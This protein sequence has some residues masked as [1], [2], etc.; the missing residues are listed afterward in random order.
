M[1]TIFI[2]L[3]LAFQIQGILVASNLVSTSER[4]SFTGI[5]GDHYETFKR[6]I[7]IFKE[8]I[9]TINNINNDN[10]VGYSETQQIGNYTTTTVS[11][12]YPAIVNSLNNQPQDFIAE[13]KAINAGGKGKIK[14]KVEKP[15]RDYINNGK[16]ELILVDGNSFNLAGSE[17]IQNY[18]GL[19]Y[20]I[21]ELE[22]TN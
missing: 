4:T 14:I 17:R 7:I 9:N 12:I 2:I 10:Y 1:E 18:L 6:D 20:Y 22:S 11:G 13:I 15:A 8:P 5:L 3:I 21:F 19:V 16:T